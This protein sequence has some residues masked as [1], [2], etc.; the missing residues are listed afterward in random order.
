MCYIIAAVWTGKPKI[1]Y[2]QSSSYAI[3][4]SEKKF[5]MGI[6]S[7][8]LAIAYALVKSSLAVPGDELNDRIDLLRKSLTHRE[9]QKIKRKANWYKTER[10]KAH[11]EIQ[12]Q[13]ENST[14]NQ[15]GWEKLNLEDDTT[16]V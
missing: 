1:H 12:R 10:G 14:T 8:N 13:E 2:I 9:R 3:F 11:V 4:G 5:N 15:E 7:K 16:Q 6:F